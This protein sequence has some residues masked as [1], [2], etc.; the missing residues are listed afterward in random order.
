MTTQN[1]NKPS[2]V[3]QAR[4]VAIGV[5]WGLV[6][7]LFVG[8]LAGDS[9]GPMSLWARAVGIFERVALLAL[10]S[11]VIASAGLF[12]MVLLRLSRVTPAPQSGEALRGRPAPSLFARFV[13]GAGIGLGILSLV[14]LALGC[15]GLLTPVVASAAVAAMLIIGAFEI[16]AVG[17][18][19]RRAERPRFPRLS[20]LELA[21]VFVMLLVLVFQTLLAFNLPT[22]YDAC[23]YHMAAPW[24]WA[25][26]GRIDTIEG[27]VYTNLPMNAEMLYLFSMKLVGGGSGVGWDRLC[28]GVH[29]G[30]VMNMMTA[31]LATAAVFVLA[32]RFWSRRA[33]FV[34][35]ALFFTMPWTVIATTIFLHNEI[36]LAFWATLA[37]HAL[38]EFCQGGTS[39][40][41]GT[42]C[43]PFPQDPEDGFPRTPSPS[44]REAGRG[45]DRQECLSY[46][47]G[48]KAA[49]RGYGVR[50]LVLSAVFAGLAA[51]VKYTALA[52]FPPVLAVAAVVVLWKSSRLKGVGAALL[53]PAVV[54]VVV[55]PWFIKNV[56]FTG[57]PVFPFAYKWFGGRDW[58]D[59][60][61]WKW[62]AGN[63]H[64]AGADRAGNFFVAAWERVVWP[65]RPWGSAAMAL[66]AGLA[67]ARRRDR[68]VVWLWALVILWTALWYFATHRVDRFWLPFAGIAAALAGSGFSLFVPS[69]LEGE[70]ER[71]RGRRA[72]A[73]VLTALLFVAVAWQ[74]FVVAINF[75]S[76][77][78][79]PQNY[80]LLTGNRAF[81][82]KRY[83]LTRLIECR[84]RARRG[85]EPSQ[86]GLLLL[87][88]EAR[89]LYLPPTTISSTVF[90]REAFTAT[91]GDPRRPDLAREG[92]EKAGIAE[93]FVNWFEVGRLRASYALPGRD[94]KRI[95]GFPPLSPADF[96]RL[97]D[98]RVL[99]RLS[100]SNPS[101]PRPCFPK[102]P[103]RVRGLTD[104]DVR[105][106]PDGRIAV[107]Y[108]VNRRGA[109]PE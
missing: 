82:A 63:Y 43:P 59:E 103:P 67:L 49:G 97:E 71:T 87:V 46:Q 93:I 3:E 57:N 19:L 20:P 61:D 84:E 104:L 23:V 68:R 42:V 79:A 73:G 16:R 69:P 99:E 60:L 105:D 6:P 12:G 47:S 36:L 10:A 91:V 48:G 83:E 41:V 77:D 4:R 37:V 24:R 85:T 9:E 101:A 52:F 8:W 75:C 35:S 74:F 51:G 40:L 90:N 92:L 70:G 1:R 58:S 66:F 29:L 30:V 102:A 65:R 98:A 17:D 15:A 53:A 14:T 21:C 13:L 78:N 45:A 55:S 89:T 22:D 2:R 28:M 38:M 54:L 108:G 25:Q 44:G 7:V 76:P 96:A 27:N 11:A 106:L 34:A 95:G 31:L 80:D 18:F 81:L 62:Y 33:A 32:R 64:A 56:A 94:G 50:W 100:D 39:R 5:A 88:G 109:P 26:V 86:G 72:A 107:L